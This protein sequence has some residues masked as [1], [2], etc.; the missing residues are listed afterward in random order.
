V[1]F[2]PKQAVPVFPLPNVVLFPGAVLP[3]HVFEL[4]YRTMVREALS[5]ERLIALALLRP[6]WERDYQGSPAFYP[7]GCLARFEEVEWLVN[8]SY[9]LKL[10]GLARVYFERIVREYPYRAARVR[11]RP[12]QP[13]SETDPLVQLEK[14]ALLETCRAWLAAAGEAGPPPALGA[15]ERVSYETL[16]GSVCTGFAGDAEAQRSLL[17]MD[18]IL[19]RGRR[20][21][22]LMEM[23]L[24]RRPRAGGGTGDGEQN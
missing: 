14:R 3:L 8:D 1:E 24:R 11:L 20:V 7:I 2:A 15:D 10:L 6:G 23:R 17:E 21:R 4:R 12:E 9:N 5:G 13:F 22:E 18:S 16:V 19:D